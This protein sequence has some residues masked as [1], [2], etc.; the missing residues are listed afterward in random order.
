MGK[1]FTAFMAAALLTGCSG[2]NRS[3]RQAPDKEV[4]LPSRDG[5]N[6][7][8]FSLPGVPL[9]FMPPPIRE[10]AAPAAEAPAPAPAPE[11]AK[12]APTATAAA[13]AQALSKQEEELQFHLGAARRYASKKQYKSAAAEYGAAKNFLPPGDKRGVNL[14]ERQGTM[15]MRAESYAAAAEVLRGAI[16]KAKELNTAGT[17]LAN[18]HIGL[19]YCLEKQGNVPDALANYEKASAISPSKAVKARLAK[20]IADLKAAPPAK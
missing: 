12:P 16:A 10:K 13:P 1:I 5:A 2:I 11:T 3:G 4:E 14:A 9:E 17:D 7:Q 18:A 20:A 15:L 6:A 19:G 8:A